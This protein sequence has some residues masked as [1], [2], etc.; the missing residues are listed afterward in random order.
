MWASIK[1]EQLG[2]QEELEYAA[3]DPGEEDK[4]RRKKLETESLILMERMYREQ[5]EEH[6]Q[7]EKQEHEG[8][9]PR[10]IMEM[11]GELY[12]KTTAKSSR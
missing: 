4:K 7:H 12:N 5:E 3:L 1:G 8:G 11:L 9:Y 10:E 6:E 2:E